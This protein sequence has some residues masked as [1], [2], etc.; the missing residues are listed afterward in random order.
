QTLFAVQLFAE[1]FPYSNEK[2]MNDDIHPQFSYLI[3]KL[4]K[5]CNFHVEAMLQRNH[6]KRVAA[7]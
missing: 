5:I 3:P 6:K 4:K 2:Y 1:Q 7:V